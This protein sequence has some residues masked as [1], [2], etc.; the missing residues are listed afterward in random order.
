MFVD[1]DWPLNASSLL[2]ASAELLVF[3][4]STA[5]R[6]LFL[7]RQWDDVA[8]QWVLAKWTRT[9]SKWFFSDKPFTTNVEISAKMPQ[10][11]LRSWGS[12]C[13]ELTKLPLLMLL[14][15]L[16]MWILTQRSI[17]IGAQC[18]TAARWTTLLN[19][20]DTLTRCC[21]DDR[22]RRHSGRYSCLIAPNS[23]FVPFRRHTVTWGIAMQIRSH[24]KSSHFGNSR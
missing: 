16:L 11:L 6:S 12:V 4:I 5:L 9:I 10:I 19:I 22:S 7:L 1:L 24:K 20:G 3:S 21:N 18:Y 15:Q 14:L 8:C 17:I 23:S 13:I 2:S